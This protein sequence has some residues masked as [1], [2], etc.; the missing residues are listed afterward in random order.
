MRLLLK[1]IIKLYP[2]QIWSKSVQRFDPESVTDG[3]SPIED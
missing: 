1:V 2:S 3:V